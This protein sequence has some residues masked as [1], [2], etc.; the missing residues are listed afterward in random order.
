MK[1]ARINP[2][3]PLA[4]KKIRLFLTL[5]SFAVALPLCLSRGPCGMPSPAA[6][7]V[8]G[9]DRLWVINRTS[10][11][12]PI[13]LSYRDKIARIPG[14]KCI[15]HDNW[16][17]GIYKMKRIS[18]RN[19]SLTRKTSARSFPNLIVP[20]DQWNAFVK[21]EQGVICRC[22]HRRTLRLENR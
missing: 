12:N 10:I 11:I 18:F 13:P 17:G 16:F 22:A 9:A 3:Q 4:K 5:G 19:L 14:V 21:T 6:P 15:T 8:A 20:D 7:M 2:C 1:F